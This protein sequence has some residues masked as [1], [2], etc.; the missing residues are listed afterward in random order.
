MTWFVPRSHVGNVKSKMQLLLFCCIFTF[1]FPSI[2]N[3]FEQIEKTIVHK[4][5]EREKLELTVNHGCQ[6][7]G[8]TIAI[9]VVVAVT[10]T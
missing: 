2:E 6:V 10:A 1:H 4:Q 3:A 9:V 5:F 8:S 7:C